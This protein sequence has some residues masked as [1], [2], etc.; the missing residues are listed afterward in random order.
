MKLTIKK[1]STDVTVYLFVQNS[2]STTG[3]GLTGLVFNSSGLVAYYV[4][5][6]GSATAITLATQTVTGAHSDGGFVEIDATNMPGWYRLDLPD[7]VCATGVNSVGIHLKGATNMAPLPLEIE[8][9][10]YDPQDA[11]RL[12]LTGIPNATPGGNGGLPTV[13]A[14]NR[15]AGIQGTITD[16]DALDTA[17][18]SQHATTQSAVSAAATNVS[19]ILGKFTGITL[20]AEWLGLIAG[21]Q[22]GNATARTELRAT[23]AGSGTYDETTDSLEANRDN[24]G[25][26]GVGLTESGGTGDQ[27]TAAGGDGSQLTEAG[28]T[29][30]H[31]TTL[32]TAAAL[33]SVASALT[34]AA[35]NVA[36][37]LG[38]WT[39]IT[40]L[41]EWLGAMA[42]LQTA[43]ATALAE[44]RA[45]GAGS[46]TFDPTADSLEA[47][48]NT[49]PLGT[50]MRGTDS[51]YTGTPPTA[52]AIAAAVLAAG[53]V[54]GYSVEETLKLQLAALVGVLAG[55]ATSTITIDAADGSKTRITATVDSDGNRSL[56]VL[57]ETG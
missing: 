33:S 49:E 11:V 31:L 26:A 50:A 13:D 39:G 9:V 8:L 10:A 54:D 37:I 3:A 16:L 43:D 52:A 38:K 14:N 56:V 15:I 46:G 18:D 7:A 17:Q 22:S 42:G 20:L 51:A 6:L 41:A 48:R 24:I 30:D 2:G 47:I 4:R 19:S 29:G 40:L 53:D 1:A 57:D 28:G 36:T 55:A 34:T 12:G 5:P 25:A 32:A 44:I 45:T 21:K 35:T 23:G 27:L